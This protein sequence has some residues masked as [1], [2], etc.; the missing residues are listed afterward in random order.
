MTDSPRTAH[1]NAQHLG[2]ASCAA[3]NQYL[4]TARDMNLAIDSAL[5]V[6]R[7]NKK[8]L[9]KESNRI[10]GEQFQAI[11]KHLIETSQDSLLG[12]KSGRY[13]QPGSYG[14]LGYI[15]MSCATLGD[16]IERI[17]P[18]E[19]LVGD[20]GVTTLEREGT[21]LRIQWHCA[22]PD[23]VVRPHMIDNVLSSWLTYAHWL[24]NKQSPPV[25]VRLERSQPAKEMIQ[26]YQDTFLCP[27]HFEQDQNSIVLPVSLLDMPL[28]QPDTQIRKTM[29][30]HA[31][32]QMATLHEQETRL[33][34]RVK[35]AILVKLKEGI[36]RKDMVAEQLGLNARTLQRRLAEDQVSYQQLLDDVRQELAKDYLSRS[37]LPFQEIAL[38]LGFSEA[39]SFHRSFKSWT[40]ETPGDY[41]NRTTKR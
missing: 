27:V 6:A 41:R 3:V 24:A 12:L 10:T 4:R 39:R 21:N 30:D 7:V 15:A 40:G 25:E 37:E 13:V 11:I 26:A 2:F 8:D 9:E 23:P 20:M 14:A 33:I 38:R 22:Y 31:Q 19:K 5:E 29:E 35:N 34:T 18:Y 16:A 32:V 36:T 17:V 1:S 28:R